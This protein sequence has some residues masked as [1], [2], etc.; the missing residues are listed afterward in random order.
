MAQMSFQWK[1]GVA[2]TLCVFV[3]RRKQLP[4][5]WRCAWHRLERLWPVDEPCPCSSLFVASK[6]QILPGRAPYLP[7][8]PP[9]AQHAP[10]CR[11]MSKRSPSCHHP[12][13]SG[14]SSCSDDENAI[15]LCRC[16]YADCTAHRAVAHRRA[17]SSLA[18]RGF[19]VN[20]FP[21]TPSM[22]S[23]PLRVT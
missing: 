19:W 11:R 22:K 3:L 16:Q 17:M 20:F 15:D 5:L 8:R 12:R 6:S 10:C 14:Q 7:D 18:G 9:L 23:V 2:L 1:T 13:S 4:T 21:P